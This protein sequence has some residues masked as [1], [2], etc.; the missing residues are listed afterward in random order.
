MLSG[1][2][3]QLHGFVDQFKD[4][5]ISHC[6]PLPAAAVTTLPLFSTWWCNDCPCRGLPKSSTNTTF[7]RVSL[8]VVWPHVVCPYVVGVALCG[9]CGLTVWPCVVG[10]A[11][12]G[13]CGLTVWPCVV[14]VA[15]CKKTFCTSVYSSYLYK[16]LLELFS[17][18]LPPPRACIAHSIDCKGLDHLIICQLGGVSHQRHCSSLTLTVVPRVCECKQG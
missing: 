9:G 13:G 4:Q 8:S 17:F 11:L 18:S 7:K 14:G 16:F 12:C 2:Q 5:V 15:L 1:N 6:P 10:V 3:R